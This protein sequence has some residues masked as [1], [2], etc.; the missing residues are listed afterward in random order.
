MLTGLMRAV[1]ARRLDAFER[2]FSYDASYMRELLDV[3][4]RG[5]RAFSRLM[6]MARHR[7]DTPPAAVY[8]AKLAATLAEDCGTCAQ[9]VI[10]M[11]EREGL[12]AAALRAIARCDVPAMPP[13]AALGYAFAC[14][15]MA[16]AP[17][18]DAVRA[19]V[20]RRWGRR[21]V[22]TLGLTVASSRMFPT[23]KYALGHGH[24]CQR[25]LVGGVDVRPL[26]AV[27]G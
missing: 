6:V 26:A 13:D 16:R 22:V 3:S 24:A 5:F 1:V 25:L 4:P 17:D 12:D 18:L 14:A 2:T 19:E 11:A 20:L 10:T 7:E 27:A 21:A 23:L 9:L 15:V 8:A